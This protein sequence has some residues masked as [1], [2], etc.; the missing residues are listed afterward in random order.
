MN[1]V[2]RAQVPPRPK[3][4]VPRDC[5]HV[6]F[7][8][9]QPQALIEFYC[10]LLNMQVVLKNSI[11]NFL[12]WDDSQDRLAILND[13]AVKPRPPG[14]AGLD[15]VAFSFGKLAD[16]TVIY[17][18]VKAQGLMPYRCMNHGVAS[19]LYYRDPDGNQIE[20]TVPNIETVEEMNA[21][22]ATGDFDENPIGVPAD[23]EEWCRRLESGESEKNL[24]RPHPEH[25]T[26]LRDHPR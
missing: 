12:T 14:V 21:W 9:A 1:Q 6:V 4:I 11:I 2:H 10:N 24:R 26:W 23:P 13:P 15:H 5:A 18:R 7:R 17:R 22:L 8:T 25:R 16:L 3:G 20:L 19:S